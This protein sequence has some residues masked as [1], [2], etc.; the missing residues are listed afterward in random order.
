[1]TGL[2]SKFTLSAGLISEFTFPPQLIIELRQSP[3]HIYKGPFDL[4]SFQNCQNLPTSF[5]KSLF[6]TPAKVSNFIISRI[7]F[8]RHPQTT[9]L[10]HHPSNIGLILNPL[11]SSATTNL[12]KN[13]HLMP[14]DYRPP[15][16]F[17]VPP[18][19]QLLLTP[20]AIKLPRPNPHLTS[21]PHPDC[22]EQKVRKRIG[23]AYSLVVG[24]V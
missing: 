18:S 1:M 10:C 12:P 9:N 16:T 7:S 24:I 17:P 21:I 3:R 4:P 5:R 2:I 20:P 15:R 6:S 19:Q 14:I 11:G 23:I 8:S 13:P 22:D